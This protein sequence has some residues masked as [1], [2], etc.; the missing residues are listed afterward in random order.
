MTF[1][2]C[3]HV[4]SDML[5]GRSPEQTALQAVHAA[6][7]VL[8][9]GVVWLSPPL[10]KS[11]HC[12]QVD[13]LLRKSPPVGGDLDGA[14]AYF[15]GE[16]DQYGGAATELAL[17]LADAAGPSLGWEDTEM[18]VRQRGPSPGTAADGSGNG[19]SREAPD[20]DGDVL[21]GDSAG[22]GSGRGAR[23]GSSGAARKE[24]SAAANI[25]QEIDGW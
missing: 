10:N 8:R 25:R 3:P 19:R 23:K 18:E 17:A 14:E 1:E 22:G 7:A 5:G 12:A 9:F 16:A 4:S 20:G 21:A 11:T 15:A 24:I 13:E 6:A 2:I